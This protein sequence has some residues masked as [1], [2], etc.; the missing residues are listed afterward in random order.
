MIYLGFSR[1]LL[2]IRVFWDVMLD[3]WL[4]SSPVTQHDIAED[5][6]SR[7]IAMTSM[8]A[9]K[10]SHLWA[11]SINHVAVSWVYF[12]AN[13]LWSF[14]SNAKRRSREIFIIF[15]YL[16]MPAWCSPSWKQLASPRSGDTFDLHCHRAYAARLLSTCYCAYD[17]LLG[18]PF[19]LNPYVFL[20][21]FTFS[22]YGVLN[23]GRPKLVI[24]NPML[25]HL[26]KFMR[27]NVDNSF[28][29]RVFLNCVYLLY[30]ATC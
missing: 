13:K 3:Q 20:S 29:L 22:L 25:Q 16:L 10:K 4:S 7:S 12:V 2:E 6:C 19:T 28:M 5:M 21:S 9:L 14:S 27:L 23:L 8:Q 24:F 11:A 1:V 30:N 17:M 18:P 26:N 15:M